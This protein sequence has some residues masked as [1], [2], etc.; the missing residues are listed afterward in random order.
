MYANDIKVYAP[1]NSAN[2]SEIHEALRSSILQLINWSQ[3]FNIPVNLSKT[4]V[5]HLGRGDAMEYKIDDVTLR[6]CDEIKDLGIHFKS[7][8]S[9][10]T[11]IRET[12]RKSLAT[13]F[14]IFR[15]VHSNNAGILVK[16]FKAYVRPTLEYG[17]QVWS[18]STEK[19]Q[20]AVEKVQQIFT[21]MLHYR[22]TTPS[23]D[24]CSIPSYALR[25]RAFKLDS[26]LYRHVVNDIVFC[27]KALKM[28]YKLKASK[29]WIFRPCCGRAGGFVLLPTS[30]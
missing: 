19:R 4:T 2:Y 28:E 22:C 6:A 12:V 21:R 23:Q 10:D 16:L 26:L 25:M 11:H 17:S 20:K 18:P 7:D 8:L 14:T 15:N 5:F 9:F 27:F 30:S 13:L 29:Y 1:Y 3:H 24:D